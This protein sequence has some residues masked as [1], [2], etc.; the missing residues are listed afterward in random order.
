MQEMSL[1]GEGKEGRFNTTGQTLKDMR[2]LKGESL[3]IKKKT[4]LTKA[5]PERSWGVT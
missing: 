3:I 5:N 4:I 1:P 2:V